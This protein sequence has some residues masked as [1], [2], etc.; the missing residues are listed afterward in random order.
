MLQLIF[1]SEEGLWTV[2]IA[3]LGLLSSQRCHDVISHMAFTSLVIGLKIFC[4]SKDQIFCI[5]GDVCT[6]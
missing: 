3:M 6:S 4:G 2:H 5:S 1:G